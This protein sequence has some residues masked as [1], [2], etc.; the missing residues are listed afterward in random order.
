MAAVVVQAQREAEHVRPTAGCGRPLGQPDGGPVPAGL[1]Q[2]SDT[3]GWSG[4]TQII[5]SPVNERPAGC[6][7][8]PRRSRPSAVL[9]RSTAVATRTAVG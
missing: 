8:R 7:S 1:V 2:Q 4:R 9:A 5:V 6:S 3:G